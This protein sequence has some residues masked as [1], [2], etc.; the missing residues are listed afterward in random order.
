MKMKTRRQRLNTPPGNKTRKTKDARTYN[1][2]Q[3]NKTKKGSRQAET[4]KNMKITNKNKEKAF[5]YIQKK[6]PALDDYHT[7]IRS[8]EEVHTWAEVMAMPNASE[9]FDIY[10]GEFDEEEAKHALECGVIHVYHGNDDRGACCFV[11]TS[12]SEA[13]EYAGGDPAHLWRSI[14]YTTEVAWI[15]TS[16]GILLNSSVNWAKMRNFCPQY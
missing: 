10:P 16:E 14:V 12:P 9:G 3:K 8:A 5:A 6:N 15:S 7:H 11:S 4:V 2:N 13:L 1:R